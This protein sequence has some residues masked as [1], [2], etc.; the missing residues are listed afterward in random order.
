[1]IYDAIVIGAGASGLYCAANIVGKKILIL[2]KNKRVGIKLLASGSGQFNFTHGGYINAFYHRYGLHK[3]FV[4]SALSRHDNRSVMAFF[5]RFGVDYVV[6]GDGKVFPKSMRAADVV[7]A[8]LKAVEHCTIMT[9]NAVVG[10]SDHNAGFEVSATKSRYLAKCVV[11]AT[12]GRSYPTMGTTGDGYAFASSM[13]LSVTETKP[14]LTG[15]VLRDKH[16]TTLQGLAL[17]SASV[18]L[19]RDG[20]IQNIYTGDLLMTHFGLSGPLIIN[21]SRDF[22]KGDL[23]KINFLGLKPET[24]ESQFLDSA[25]NHG[26]KPLSFFLNQLSCPETLKQFIMEKAPIVRETKLSVIDKTQR[27]WLVDTLT[28]YHVEIENLIGFQQAMVTVGGVGLEWVNPKTMES[29]KHRGLFFIGE[30]LDVDGDTGGYNLQWAFSSGYAA[31]MQI[32]EIIGG[33]NG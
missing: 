4:K 3:K 22:T 5:N 1:M 13:G 25:M 32:N 6:R 26:D 16:L 14:G 17:T 30:V 27:K 23:I 28:A 31:A 11:V 8:L 29:V 20:K 33:S 2:E 21:N 15:V 19:V 24:L 18:T 9:D 7:G 12:G 10:I